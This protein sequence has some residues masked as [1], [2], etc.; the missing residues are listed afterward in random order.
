[1][2]GTTPT[3][4]SLPTSQSPDHGKRFA[5]LFSLVF[6]GATLWPIQQNW[7]DKPHDNFP[8]SYYP[9][10]SAR[11]DPIETF[12]YLLGRDSK[13]GRYQVPYKW[14]GDGGGNQVRRQLRRTINE[15]HALE[16]AGIV[17]KRVSRRTEPPWTDVVSIEVVTGKYSV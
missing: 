14:I 3:S 15:G 17:A 10:F 6:I 4:D 13:G 2:N 9:M 16:L 8:L 7:R 11:R 12:H 1:M 5:L